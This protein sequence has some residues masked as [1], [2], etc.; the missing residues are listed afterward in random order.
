MD[1]A[2]PELQIPPKRPGGQREESANASEGFPR[3]AI[4]CD[5]GKQKMLLIYERHIVSMG[6]S[7]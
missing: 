4:N 6:V 1:G 3:N 2:G 7:R 5:G